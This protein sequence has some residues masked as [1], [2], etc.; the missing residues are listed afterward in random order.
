MKIIGS[1]LSLAAIL[2]VPLLL[3]LSFPA[4][5]DRTPASEVTAAAPSGEA[6]F[7][8]SKCSLC[9]GIE[10][11]GIEGKATSERMKSPDLSDVGAD[12]GA[13]WIVEYLKREIEVGGEKHPRPF[14]GSDQDARL[15]ADWLVEPQSE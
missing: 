7:E 5:A 12:R 11:R 9:H 2:G 4:M 15:I 1:I 13:D 6:L 10:T 14:T 3:A 8:S